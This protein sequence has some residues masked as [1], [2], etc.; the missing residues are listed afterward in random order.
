MTINSVSEQI[1]ADDTSVIISS[2]NLE[3]FCSVSNLVFSHMIKCFVVNNLILEL[4][5]T[6]IIKF[7][8]KSSSHSTLHTGCKEK[9]IEE[10]VNTKLI[11]TQFGRPILLK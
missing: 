1:Y 4:D 8:T 9:C 5:K 7:I 11:T 3:D 2:R 10:T 6:N